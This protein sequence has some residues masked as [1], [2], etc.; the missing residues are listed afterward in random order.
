MGTYVFAQ[1]KLKPV[2]DRN[3]YELVE[4][5]M[6]RT[7][8]GDFAVPA[9]FMYDGASIPRFFWRVTGGPFQSPRCIAALLHDYLY[10]THKV[11]RATADIIYRD[12]QFA[13]GIAK[14]K[15]RI[16]YRAL[17]IFGGFAW[18][19]HG[20]MNHLAALVL[21]AA[22]SLLLD[23][24]ASKTRSAEFDGLYAS[25]TGTLAI[26]SVE[27]TSAPQGEESAIIKYEEDNAWLAPSMQKHKIK[28]TLT[29]TNSVEKVDSIVQHICEAFTSVADK[30]TKATKETE[31]KE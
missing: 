17:R 31:E 27:V 26:G 28:I 11:D 3:Y 12:M 29:G 21:L 19:N 9:G 25:E 16:E 4:S 2:L 23:G 1:P 10:A 14:Y 20:T 22:I 5:W 24:C 7:P 18:R 15:A 30:G 6:V 8:Y 13:L